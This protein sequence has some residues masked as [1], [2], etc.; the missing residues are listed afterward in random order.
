M[1]ALI[2]WIFIQQETA[3]FVSAK[4]ASSGGC[5]CPTIITICQMC[6]REF[7]TFIKIFSS[8]RIN[9]QQLCQVQHLSHFLWAGWNDCTGS[10]QAC[11]GHSH[12]I[13]FCDVEMM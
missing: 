12:M 10:L 5:S 11:D 2:S 3:I 9:T 13:S 7:V 6:W 8:F 1:S 4:H